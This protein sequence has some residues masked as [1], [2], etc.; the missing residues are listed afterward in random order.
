MESRSNRVVEGFRPALPIR[1]DRLIL[2]A[3]RIEDLDDL[4]SFHGDPEVIRFVPW[5]LRDRAATEAALRIKLD[6]AHLLEPGQWLVL[7]VEERTTATVIGEVLLKWTSAS[8]HQ[9]EIGFAFGREF[10]GH[11]YATEAAS[12]MLNVGFNEVGLHRISAV[13]IQENEDSARLLQRL[14][15]SQQ[16]RL[17]DN[18]LFKGQWATQLLF[19]LTEDQWRS[20][21]G[22][23]SNDVGQILA[24]VRCFFTAFTSGDGTSARLAAL[25]AAMLADAVIVR[26]C[27]QLPAVYD[28]ES[29]I[30]PRQTLLTDGSLVD[31]SERA[32]T[33][34]VDVFGDIAHWFGRYTKD[35]LFH[36]QPYPGGGMKSMQFVRTGDGWRIS[37]AAWDDE[38]PGLTPTDHHTEDVS[39]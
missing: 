29:F 36:G 16:G 35:G 3:H 34:R 32:T 13:C 5:P 11:G 4:V 27:G 21:D 9:G 20:D 38:R 14:G 1:T 6:Q 25:R 24:L 18:V 17:V 12:A 15:F 2:R 19:A 26:T 30:A 28:V 39:V 33:G 10:H 8:D 22:P 31:F 37:A 7:A 23:T